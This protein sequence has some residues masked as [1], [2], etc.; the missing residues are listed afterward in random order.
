MMSR[1]IFE[2]QEGL[3]TSY[4]GIPTPDEGRR[5]RYVLV[6]GQ[7]PEASNSLRLVSESG[8]GCVFER[9]APG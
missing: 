2:S 1:G 7:C 6:Y 4:F 5:A 9:N 3:P 8:Q